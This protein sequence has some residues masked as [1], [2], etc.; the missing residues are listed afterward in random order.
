MN[1]KALSALL[2]ILALF[3]LPLRQ[4][5]AQNPITDLAA[6][7]VNTFGSGAIQLINTAIDTLANAGGLLATVI[8][9]GLSLLNSFITF[10]ISLIISSGS[11]VVAIIVSAISAVCAAWIPAGCFD[12]LDTV[13]ALGAAVAHT[14][15]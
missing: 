6:T 10:I 7:G 4:A 1:L 5:Q 3:A 15:A 11:S 2:V 8:S 12:V 14:S 9:V 13:L